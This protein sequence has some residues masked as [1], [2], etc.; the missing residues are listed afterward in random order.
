MPAQKR[1]NV[2]SRGPVPSNAEVV[3]DALREAIIKGW[4]PPGERIKEIPLSR[5]LGVSRGPI[6]DALRLLQHDGLVTIIPNKGAVVPKPNSLDV[7]EV[8]AM[9]AALGSLALRKLML[10]DIAVPVST[11][12]KHFARLERAA[13]SK[14]GPNTAYADLAYQ[15]A[16]VAASQ[17]P[18]VIRQFD[19]LRWQVRI[20]MAVRDLRFDDKVSLIVDEIRDLH[21]AIAG[22][23]ETEAE[24][25]WREKFERWVRNFMD[26][27]DEHFDR[28]LWATLTSGMSAP[29]SPQRAPMQ[30]RTRRA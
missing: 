24:R 11:L 1:L 27:M 15:S 29:D 12:E 20:F 13:Q 21:H 3:A 28:E 5:Q 14:S 30:S 19:Q 17:L 8:Y 18:R 25:L 10:S 9:R 26:Q 4:L 2:R 22:Q 6:R 16:V 23:L 7:L